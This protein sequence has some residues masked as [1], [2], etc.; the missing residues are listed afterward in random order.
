MQSHPYPGVQSPAYILEAG[1]LRRN[2]DLVAS[3]AEA[4]DV[5]II[6]ALK[7]FAMWRAFPTIGARLHGATASSLNEARL[8]YEEMGVKAHTYCVAYRADEFEELLGYSS[9]MVFNSAAQFKRFGPLI[10]AAGASVSCGIRINP[11]YSVTE[12]D[13][14]N[15]A[16]PGSRLGET[17]TRLQAAFP[18]GLP[19]NVEGLHFHTLCE[20][21][22]ADLQATLAAVEARFGQYFSQLKWIN[23]GGGHLM[24]HPD[25]DTDL[26]I[27]TLQ[28]FKAKHGIEVILEPG[29]AIVYR[30]GPLLATV[31]DIHHSGD[32]AT[33][34]LDVSFTA[35]MPDTLEMPYRPV[36]RGSVS[37]TE[38]HYAYRMGGVSCLAG[39][40]LEAYHFTAPLQVGDAIILEDM[41]HYTTV[42]TTMF[43]GV[44][45]PDLCL[46][47]KDGRVEVLRRFDYHDYRNR[48]A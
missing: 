45:H 33:A 44:R 34:I 8:I 12:T 20:G 25:Y 17:L 2:L 27:A 30:T 4:A 23:M 40:Y 13:L 6:L 42:K 21:T 1:L 11:E 38:G 29:S 16:V 9:H 43:N 31:L 46:Q 24:T 22:A 19:A 47:H 39:D 41:N 10:E 3:V 26:L 7:A 35:H 36:I 18:D 15:P 28:A 37:D 48:M 5:H 14:Y 32:I